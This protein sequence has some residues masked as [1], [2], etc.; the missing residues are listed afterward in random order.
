MATRKPPFKG[1]HTVKS[2]GQTYYYAFRGGPRI[3][4]KFGTREFSEEFWAARKPSCDETRFGAWV[5]KFK[6]D[7]AWKKLS[8]PTK[9]N[10]EPKLDAAREHFGKLPVR[11]FDTASIRRDIDHWRNKWQDTPRTADMAKQA[12]SRLCSY[13]VFHGV[14]HINPCDGIPNLYSANRAATIWTEED[15]AKLAE[16]APA[17][18]MWAAK[19]AAFT[20]LRQGDLLALPW[21]RVGELAIET[22][23]RKSKGKRKAVIPLTSAAR[24]FLKGVPRRALTVLTNTGGEPWKTGFGS[25]WQA[26]LK[27]SGLKESGLHFHDLRG[28]AATNFYRAGLTLREIAEI[29]GW[30][31]SYVEEMVNTY[32]KKDEILRDR[33]RRME[34]TR[35]R[36]VKKAVKTVC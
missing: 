18:I 31:E 9:K 23:T 13:M 6:S 1:L 27:R 19:L 21:S 5:V 10:W 3:E 25:S 4:A 30:S 24:E 33:I 35:T 17:E 34:R 15:I 28:T 2:N 8:D 14:L 22:P 26:A 7:D 11:V 36:T 29:M 32:V 16:T 12:L 20:G